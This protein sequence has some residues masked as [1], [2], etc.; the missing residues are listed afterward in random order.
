MSHSPKMPIHDLTTGSI[1]RHLIRFSLP[2]LA[3]N[4]LQVSYGIINTM[5]VGNFLGKNAL[6][7][8]TNGFSVLFLLMSV[9]MGLTMATSILISQYCGA[10]EWPQ[11]KRVVQSS[12]SL[13]FGLSFVLMLLGIWAT[14]TLLHA[15]QT[16]G[17]ALGMANG[18]L[19]IFFFTLPCGFGFYLIASMLRGAGDSLT[20]LK[21][22]VVSVVMTAVL[23]PLL[24]LGKLGFPRMGLNGTAVSAFAA[25]VIALTALVVYLERRRHLVAPDFRRLRS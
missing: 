22:Q 18:Y 25:Q 17:E 2:M 15:I 6:T 9:G 11:V 5:W 16:P 1:P 4:L 13:L 20:P 24:M 14:P 19:R 8:A 23:D 3:G 21:F 12:T 10:K 7:A